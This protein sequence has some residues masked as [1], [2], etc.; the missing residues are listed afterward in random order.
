MSSSKSFQQDNPM[1]AESNIPGPT[2]LTRVKKSTLLK[3][4]QKSWADVS[5]D[6]E[7]EEASVSSVGA[8]EVDLDDIFTGGDQPE[9]HTEEAHAEIVEEK[10]KKPNLSKNGKKMGRPRKT[11]AERRADAED[12]ARQAQILEKRRQNAKYMR[13]QRARLKRER[14]E[15]EA[16]AF[17][18][19]ESN[20]KRQEESLKAL[21]RAKVEAYEAERKNLS[22][23]TAK[24]EAL[25]AKIAEERASKKNIV[26]PMPEPVPEPVKCQPIK[27]EPLQVVDTPAPPKRVFRFL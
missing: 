4:K 23:I 16:R 25:E 22:K 5:S 24:V 19:S 10:K 21:E 1:C 7:D 14:F 20:V 18:A 15:A 13:D 3:P 9:L 6:S 17:V 11:N 2:P 8:S 12:A 27:P 26:I